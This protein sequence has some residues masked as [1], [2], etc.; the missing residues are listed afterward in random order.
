LK[1]ED[2]GLAQDKEAEIKMKYL[3]VLSRICWRRNKPVKYNTAKKAN[4]Q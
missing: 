3:K 2:N 1:T 4:E